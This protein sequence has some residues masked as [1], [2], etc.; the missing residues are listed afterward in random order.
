MQT[1][2]CPSHP[3]TALLHSATETAPAATVAP[4]THPPARPPAHPPTS[5]GDVQGVDGVALPAGR[6]AGI[7]IG[8]RGIRSINPAVILKG[9]GKAAHRAASRACAERQGRGAAGARD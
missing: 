4:P 2:P 8:K 5:G 3:A 7:H 9:C 6:L 1:M